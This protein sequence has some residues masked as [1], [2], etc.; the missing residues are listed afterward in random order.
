MIF[1]LNLTLVQGLCQYFSVTHA[2]RVLKL[3]I[4]GSM[5]LCLRGM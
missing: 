1:D 5:T 4:V 3:T 2:R